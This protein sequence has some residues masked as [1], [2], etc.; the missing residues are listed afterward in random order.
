M[1]RAT[2]VLVF[3]LVACGAPEDGVEPATGAEET[4]TGSTGAPTTGG[5]VEV[6]TSSE[7]EGGT[8]WFPDTGELGEGGEVGCPS[9]G[10]SMVQCSVIEQ[11]CGCEG[12]K[13]APVASSGGSWDAAKCVPIAEATVPVGAP[14]V[15]PMGGGAGIDD[16]EAGALC[17]HVDE[18]TK[19]GVCV[20]LC[21]GTSEAPSC[22]DPETVCSISN[23]GVLALCVRACD[24]LASACGADELCAPRAGGEPGFVCVPDASGAGGASFDPCSSVNG[25][26]PGLVCAAVEAASEC[27]P[28]G[29]SCCLP[30]CDLEL[31]P[32]CP[33]VGQSCVPWFAPG[34]AP[35]GL[36]KVGLCAIEP[37]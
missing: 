19:A 33:G 36:E 31:P 10:L 5:S 2:W 30:L 28:A 34:E 23:D 9:G 29:Y 7:G 21:G 18:A 27:D 24:P 37:P 3:G 4:T 26:D 32:A 35:R 13:C 6:S 1:K 20:A 8:A 14:C 12:E 16:C 17:W 22:E 15:A 11:D 25:C